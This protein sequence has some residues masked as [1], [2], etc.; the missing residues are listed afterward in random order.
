DGDTGRLLKE[1]KI[2]VLNPDIIVLI[3]KNNECEHLVKNLTG[4]KIFRVSVS[5]FVRTKTY[6]ERKLNRK[7]SLGK[8]LSNAQTVKL[9]LKKIKLKRCFFTSGTAEPI[10]ENYANQISYIEK[11]GLNE[12]AFI[13]TKKK[14]EKEKLADLKKKYNSLKI[15]VSGE[16]SGLFAGLMNESNDYIGIGILEKIDIVRDNLYIKTCV[17]AQL[18]KSITLGLV[19]LDSEGNETGYVEPG[20]I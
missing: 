7:I 15:M 1:S 9:S 17:D 5:N 18:I 2:D 12:G 4:R 20:T 19:K 13:I 3:Q 10:P 14:I 8:Y 11:L 6:E 16:E